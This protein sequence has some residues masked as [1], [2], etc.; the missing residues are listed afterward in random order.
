[1]VPYFRR[2]TYAF[3][4]FFSIL[5]HSRVPDD[6][7]S[8]L[9]Q[10]PAKVE[11]APAAAAEPP[12]VDRATQLL[13]LLQRDGRLLDF[14]MEDLGAYGDAQIGAAARDVHAGCRT[15]LTRYLSISP[16]VDE[17]EGQRLTVQR[18]TDPAQIK[19]V[20]NISGEP[21]YTGVVRHRGWRATRIELPPVPSAVHSVL[22]PAEIEVQ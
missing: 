11:T 15:V 18:G 9:G 3:R 6:V 21:P 16:V 19:V 5:D 4:S 1:M 13:A 22:A 10:G 20:G 7:V 2:V 8:A 14:L 12:P 17:E